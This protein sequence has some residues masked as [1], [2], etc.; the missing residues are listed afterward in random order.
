MRGYS[1]LL[2]TFVAM[3]A[4]GCGSTGTSSVSVNAATSARMS[5]R[6]ATATRFIAAADAICGT[7]RA[8]QQPLN[9]RVEALGNETAAARA[10]LQVL[11]RR[12]VV[13]ASAA[14]ARLRALPQP[15]SEAATIDRL[16]A[17]Y[18]HEAAQVSGFA[19]SLTSREPEGQKF[20]SASLERIT[21]SDRKLAASLGLK[22][23]A[24]AG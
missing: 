2:L 7:L 23:C 14:Q 13:F 16:L 10:Q 24:A 5:T 19:D 9:D 11:L 6:D 4:T 3:T 17:G 1:A 22:V 15:P 21:A 18:A 8:Q 20:S 12:S